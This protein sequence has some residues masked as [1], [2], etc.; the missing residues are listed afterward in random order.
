MSRSLP[1]VCG[2]ASATL[3][4]PTPASLSHTRSRCVLPKGKSSANA[5][6]DPQTAA[7]QHFGNDA[8]AALPSDHDDLAH[9][10]PRDGAQPRPRAS[11]PWSAPA[12]PRGAGW[13]SA[14]CGLAAPRGGSAVWS[15][16]HIRRRDAAQ[17]RHAMTDSNIKTAVAVRLLNSASAEATCRY[18]YVG[19]I[20]V[21][22]MSQLFPYGDASSFNEDI[23][24]WDTSGV[25]RTTCSIARPS[26]GHRRVSRAS[27][28]DYMFY[29]SANRTSARAFLRQGRDRNASRPSTRTS[30]RHWAS[31]HELHVL[32]RL[33]LGT[34]AWT[35]ASLG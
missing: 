23:G 9:R 10:R 29:A 27:I 6:T 4:S 24:A 34:S 32:L 2:L 35:P 1:W 17:A 12:A 33:G 8:D 30:A 16:K 19:H 20:G 21:T 26:T 14:C 18:F 28:K 13:P 3:L 25:T 22:D 5:H 15:G 11:A 31:I 7:R